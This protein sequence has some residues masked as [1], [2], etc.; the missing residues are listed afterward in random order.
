MFIYEG[1]AKILGRAGGAQ[2]FAT[3][4]RAMKEKQRY[5]H[6]GAEIVGIRGAWKIRVERDRALEPKS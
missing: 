2:T 6:L 3:W 1:R 4:E 5:A